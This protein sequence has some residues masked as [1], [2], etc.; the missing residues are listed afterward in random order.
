VVHLG[1]RRNG[2]KPPAIVRRRQAHTSFG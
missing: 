1:R 2:D